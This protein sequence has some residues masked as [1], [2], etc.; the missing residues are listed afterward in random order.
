M[1]HKANIKKKPQT[2]KKLKKNGVDADLL[3]KM[4]FYSDPANVEL[5][6]LKFNRIHPHTKG[7]VQ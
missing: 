3:H 2:A 7:L 5:E 6:F 4:E 1:S